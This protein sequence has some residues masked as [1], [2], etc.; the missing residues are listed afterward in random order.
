[1]LE[2]VLAWVRGALD[3]DYARLA[4]AAARIL[5]AGANEDLT[6]E[7][8]VDNLWEDFLSFRLWLMADMVAEY[9]VMTWPGRV[10]MRTRMTT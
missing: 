8:L 3:R 9:G 4:A 7:Q 10:V 2:K 6:V 1:M 5:G